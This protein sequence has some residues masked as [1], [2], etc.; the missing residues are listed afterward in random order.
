ML[1]GKNKNFKYRRPPPGARWL[2]NRD[3]PS[4]IRDDTEEHDPLVYNAACPHS[5]D[6]HNSGNHHVI[7]SHV[8]K[9]PSKVQNKLKYPHV[10][11]KTSPTQRTLV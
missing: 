5:E 2:L 4:E 10:T 6:L 9:D 7:K 3:F 8:G 11:E 1:P